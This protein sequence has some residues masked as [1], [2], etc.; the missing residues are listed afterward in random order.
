M[1]RIRQVRE[2]DGSLSPY[3]ERKVA[4]SIH[5]ALRRADPTTAR[6]PTS[7]PASSRSSSSARIPRT[8]RAARRRRDPGHRGSASCA[9]RGTRPRRAGSARSGRAAGGAAR[10]GLG[11]QHAPAGRFRDAAPRRAFR[12]P[13]RRRAGA[14][15]ASCA[16]S[17]STPSCRGP[18]PRRSRSRSS[19]RSSR[20]EL[21]SV[22]ADLVRHLVACELFERGLESRRRRG[23]AHPDFRARADRGRSSRRSPARALPR[24]RSPRPCSS[25]SRSRRSTAPRSRRRTPRARCTSTASTGRSRSSGSRLPWDLAR[26]SR[27]ASG[28]R[29]LLDLRRTL[30]ALRPRVAGAIELPD[31]VAVLLVGGARIAARDRRPDRRRGGA[32]A[33]GRPAGPAIE[34][35]VPLDRT[36]APTLRRPRRRACSRA[37]PARSRVRLVH[38]APSP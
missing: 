5:Q 11:P 34:I 26:A 23:R 9:R 38:S 33:Y 30:D 2:A 37:S 14:G 31:A 3:R 16:R 8:A 20:S 21:K 28:D 6:S 7:S 4:E 32:D 1:G 25:T 13:S 15:R 12:E 17:R 27:A 10:P 24:R 19:A 36:P 35:A 22:S 29:A 18:S